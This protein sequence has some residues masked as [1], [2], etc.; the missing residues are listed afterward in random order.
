M[1]IFTIDGNIGAGKSTI[2][3]YLHNHYRISIDP[4]PVHKW[5]PFLEE[6]YRNNRGAFE[7][8]VRVWLDRCWIQTR[9]NMAPIL[10]ER[11]PYF[12][13][14]VFI[15]TM[16]EC[17]KVNQT[18]YCMLQEMYAKSSSLWSPHGCIY[19]RSNPVKCHERIRRRNRASEEEITVPY[20][21]KLHTFH[22][23][24]YMTA[25]SRGMPVICIDIEGK[26]VPQVASEVWVALCA[27]G[28]NITA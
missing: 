17:G 16:L 2:L 20:L 14:N 24:A 28:L 27:L 18:E 23:Y 19:L 4:E 12:Q 7:F 25:V 11:S 6:M 3:E 1:S 15:P 21:F 5:Q 13:S 9:P 8:Q 22:E 26:T 10:M